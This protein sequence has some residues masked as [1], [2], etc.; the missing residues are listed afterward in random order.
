M[1][2]YPA[3][4][5]EMGSWRYF[6][7][8]MSMRELAE[9]VKL[10]HDVHDDKTL[11]TA[12]QRVLREG[13]AHKDIIPYLKYQEDRFFGSIV[14]AAINGNP[15]WQPVDMQDQEGVGL[16]GRDERLKDSFGIL[17]FD[18]TQDYYALDGQHRL[19]AIKALVDPSNPAS[20]GAPSGFKN[21]EVS[22]I[23]VMPNEHESQ[24]E[25]LIRYRRLFGNLNRYAKPMDKATNII[26]DEDDAFAIIT[27]RLISEH[28]HFKW[29]GVQKDSERIDCKSSSGS[30]KKGSPHFTSLVTLYELTRDLLDSQSRRNLGWDGDG[31]SQDDLQRFRPS[32]ETLD[33]LYDELSAIWDGLLDALPGLADEPHLKRHTDLEEGGFEAGSDYAYMRPQTQ[34]LVA[35]IARLLID[36]ELLPEQASDAALVA[37]ALAPLGDLNW[38][39]HGV[40]WRHVLYVPTGKEEIRVME[41]MTQWKMRGDERPASNSICMQI[42]LWQV[43]AATQDEDGL[44]E[45]RGKWE[46]ILA[47]LP[48]D[49]GLPY[50]DSMWAEIEA[51]V[52]R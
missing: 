6:I 24:D 50:V 41:D 18:G 38:E 1:I 2:T 22:V 31:K 32:D 15:I 26:M 45:L 29:D 14:V 8:R 33:L 25:F 36:K 23:V 4:K 46:Q 34:R 17:A 16:A 49:E 30:L 21:E 35:Q 48:F 42:L 13:R 28:P 11:A 9:S 39:L 5:A 3:L 7:V 52:L 44:N 40:P 10:A 12:I 47:T 27:R 43:G 37:E 19:Y 51:G 20:L